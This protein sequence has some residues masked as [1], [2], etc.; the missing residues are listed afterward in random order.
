M[1]PPAVMRNDGFWVTAKN[2]FH[3]WSGTYALDEEGFRLRR[4]H[5]FVASGLVILFT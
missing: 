2:G 5:A 4:K 3:L 1:C